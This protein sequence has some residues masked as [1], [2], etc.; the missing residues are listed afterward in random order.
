MATTCQRFFHICSDIF[1]I[2]YKSIEFG[3]GP[4]FSRK[5]IKSLFINFGH[6]IDEIK[7]THPI[8]ENQYNIVENTIF[9]MINRHCTPY[10]DHHLKKLHL[11]G[12][13]RDVTQ[14]FCEL[15]PITNYLNELHLFGCIIPYT[16]MELFNICPR[17]KELTIV[18]CRSNR[19]Y[20]NCRTCNSLTYYYKSNPNLIKMTIKNNSTNLG[21]VM[22]L[23]VAHTVAPNLQELTYLFNSTGFNVESEE[24]KTIPQL[25]HLKLLKM[26]FT[27]NNVKTFLMSLLA[28][29][30]NI[31]NLSI[32]R[33]EYENDTL[34]C[35]RNFKR[36]KILEII[37]PQGFNFID[38]MN[39]VKIGPQL[40]ALHLAEIEM[41]ITYTELKTFITVSPNLLLLKL[42][43]WN[44]EFLN[45]TTY[46]ELLK[47][48]QQRHTRE[49]LTIDLRD[50]LNYV[51][52]P[53]SILNANSK[54]LLIL[55]N[56]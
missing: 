39:L 38:F 18:S 30:P 49:P 37:S 45:E 52:V 10:G 54:D 41:A 9:R 12:F 5:Q 51:N 46:F 14:S 6:L 20:N 7:I 28:N 43:L 47:I 34:Y 44:H 27:N 56:D 24:I 23:H 16:F 8:F 11:K 15:P 3:S 35:L 40:E 22:F 29:N 17:I 21:T 31:I 25:Q 48:I 32:V 2:K 42:D 4:Y 36:L 55:T 1:R 50:G 53:E 26:E 19:N 33:G 13:R